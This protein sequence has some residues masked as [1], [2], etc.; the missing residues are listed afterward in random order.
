M[1]TLVWTPPDNVTVVAATHAFRTET[2]R[3]E[4][5]EGATLADLL[6]LAGVPE[7]AP[8]RVWI[9]DWEIARAS[10]PH[11]RPKAGRRVTI[12][13]VP[14]GGGGGDSNKGL[15]ILLLVVIIV[16]A[17]VVTVMTWGTLGPAMA[18]MLGGLI[19]SLG[20]FAVNALLP[21]PKPKLSDLASLGRAAPTYSLTGTRNQL[22]PYQQV[23]RVYGR[24]RIFPPLAGYPTTWSDDVNQILA[25]HFC[26]GYGP[27]V[28][29][30]V[31][32]GDTPITDYTGVTLELRPGY[33]DD[34][35]LSYPG[36]TVRYEEPLS[37]TLAQDVE[38][39]HAGRPDSDYLSIEVT[40]PQGLF[41]YDDR[42]QTFPMATAFLVSLREL[43]PDGLPLTDW[44]LI[45]HWAFNENRND[46]L[47]FSWQFA[48]PHRG[49]WEVKMQKIGPA[50]PGVDNEKWVWTAA[51]TAMRSIR[52]ENPIAVSGMAQIGLILTASGQLSGVVDQLNVIATSILPD[53]NGATW[54]P[55]PTRNP[56]SIY[57]DI[58]RGPATARPIP[59][60]LID[61]PALQEWHEACA[62]AGYT[63]DAVFDAAG[64]VF[65]NLNSVAAIGRASFSMRDGKY[66]VVRD[67]PQTVPVQFFTPRNSSEFSGR[68]TYQPLPHALKVK[69]INPAAHWTQDERY[70]YDDGYDASNATRFEGLELFGVTDAELAWRHGRYWIAGGRLRPETYELTVD[71]EYLIATRGDLVHV[72]HDVPL[73]GLGS[74]RLVGIGAPLGDGSAEFLLDEV[75]N[76]T[77]GATLALRIRLQDSSSY[78]GTAIAIPDEPHRTT[79]LYV[80]A[81]LPAAN[82]GDLAMVGEIGTETVACVIKAIEPTDNLAAKLTLV[83][84]APEIHDA[85]TGAIPPFESHVTRQPPLNRPAPPAPVIDV[86]RTDEWVMLDDQPSLA[87]AFHVPDDLLAV[88]ATH[89][90]AQYRP[91]DSSAEWI[92]LPTRT[93][94]VSELA[95]RPL[96][97]GR[98]Y[99]VRLRSY[100]ATLSMASDWTTATGVLVVGKSSLPPDPLALSLDAEAVELRWLYPTPPPDLDGFLVRYAPGPGANW[101]EAQPLHDAVVSDTRFHLPP[102]TGTFT[103]LVKAV[104][105]SGNQSANPTTLVADLVAVYENIVREEDQGA[106][107]WPGTATGLDALPGPPPELCTRPAEDPLF[108]TTDPRLFWTLDTAL[109]WGAAHGP[110]AYEVAIDVAP[111]DLGAILSW[112]WR[113]TSTGWTLQYR[114]SGDSLFWSSAGDLF[115][116]PD[117]TP[118]WPDTSTWLPWPGA[119]T[120]FAQRYDFRWSYAGGPASCLTQAI[121]RLDVPDLDEYLTAVAIDVAG[122]RL[123]VAGDYRSITMVLLTVQQGAPGEPLRTATVVDKDV[124][125]PLVRLNLVTTGAATAGIVDAHVRGY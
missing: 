76:V 47:R 48:L 84:A 107:G 80:P 116:E 78:L 9:D 45:R 32:I 94:P 44:T 4:I 122:T 25:E 23:P 109:F 91:S 104:D 86:V 82:V 77:P 19:V 38:Y 123:P 92:T 117:P 96:E 3:L 87:V 75:L 72:Q 61:W 64:T 119:I 81:P 13:V 66:S 20:S 108:W 93:M 42:N 59:D 33:P 18:M 100:N 105:T 58:L 29:E 85:D 35:P 110:G 125:G 40:F 24:H 53:W 114:T 1:S 14:S 120:A 43:G 79:R 118:F 34:A 22:A 83:D 73:W 56:A 60:S 26:V 5:P 111:D 70:V 89:I 63:F 101:D 102:L 106:L 10:W 74:G 27:L 8:V 68:K 28:L 67:R 37:I 30:D 99:D 52:L 15:R 98:S 49:H 55:A 65:E 88:P 95:I 54:E 7:W 115:W 57:L 12:R 62:A 16:I 31:R 121:L 69:F 46:T 6:Q 71:V 50:G 112:D 124:A 41:F 36:W 2:L 113:A 90:Q 17:I 97:Q 39:A 21:P 11:V 51:W 103:F